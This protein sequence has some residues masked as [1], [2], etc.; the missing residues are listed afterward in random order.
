MKNKGLLIGS[1]VVVLIIFIFLYQNTN[2]E[3]STDKIEGVYNRKFKEHVVFYPQHQDDEVLWG[4]S[5]IIK[6]TQECGA[7]NVYIVLVSDGSGVNFFNNTKY[8]DLSRKEKEEFRNA[9]FEAA[10]KE[11]GVKDKNIII[12]ADLEEHEGTHFELMEKVILEFEEKL[13]SVTHIAHHYKYDNHP[14]H[15]KNGKVLKNLKDEGLITDAIY[16]VKPKYIEEI[17]K[18]YRVIYE[19]NSKAEADKVRRACYE[20]KVV[21]STNKK[22]GIG[23]TSA[24]SYFDHLLKDPRLRSFLSI[25]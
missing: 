6:A 17:P 14:M 4:G 9:E 22:L 5:A 3:K 11:L 16:F 12:L 1:V 25:K 23:Y 10:L 15:R 13:G 20:Y 21:D 24:H 2:G 8:K 18:E 19:V 7:D